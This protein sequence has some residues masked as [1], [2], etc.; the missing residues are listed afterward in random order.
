MKTR[1]D[2][3]G[4]RYGRLIVLSDAPNRAKNRYF[5]CECDCGNLT[6]VGYASLATGDTTSCGCFAREQRRTR[7]PNLKHGLALTPEYFTWIRIKTRCFNKKAPKYPD[8]GGRGITMCDEWK[9]SFEAFLTHVGQKPA[10]AFSLDRVDNNRGYEPGNVRWA[11]ATEQANNR[12][13]NLVVTHGGVTLT[14]AEWARR[15]NVNPDTLTQ[16][17]R[18]GWTVERTLQS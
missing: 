9:A 13:S 18:R 12:R 4:A 15:L 16:R 1:K 11:T 2:F 7:R 3:V 5:N 17:L 6:E 10:W 8:Y 14:I